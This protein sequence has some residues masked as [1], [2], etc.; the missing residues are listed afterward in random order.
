MGGS[1]WENHGAHLAHRLQVFGG[2]AGASCLSEDGKRMAIER[3]SLRQ[4]VWRAPGKRFG[5]PCVPDE[6]MKDATD[7]IRWMDTDVVLADPLA[8][9]MDS[10]ELTTALDSKRFSIAF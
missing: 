10:V 4:S 9:S 8:K 7:V 1:S 5:D 6:T 3:A 2:S